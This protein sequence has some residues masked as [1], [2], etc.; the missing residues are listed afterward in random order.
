MSEEEFSIN[1]AHEMGCHCKI[2]EWRLEGLSNQEIIERYAEW[3]Q[4]QTAK[5]GW[6]VHFV[7]DDDTSPTGFNYHTHGLTR[8]DHM[9]L[10]IVIP[11]PEKVAMGL[12]HTMADRIKEGEKFNHGDVVSGIAK[13]FDVKFYEAVES[14]RPVL[15]VIIPDDTNNLGR[16][17]KGNLALQYADL[18]E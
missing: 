4:E 18:E 14:E 13:N 6:I 12:F 8:Y 9:D 15:R 11:L 2:C 7:V 5:H 1:G 10:Q 17:M 16:D 3:Q